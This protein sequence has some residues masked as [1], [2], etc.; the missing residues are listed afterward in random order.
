MAKSQDDALRKA[1]KEKHLVY[2]HGFLSSSE[3]FKA[4]VCE[5]YLASETAGITFHCPSLSSRPEADWNQ[6]ESLLLAI[7]QQGAVEL[8]VIGSSL[9]G[10]WAGA[11]CKQFAGLRAVLINPAVQPQNL[12]ADRIGVAL[13]YWHGEGELCLT[14]ADQSFIEGIEQRARPSAKELRR[15][16]VL[17]QKG[18]ETLD[19]RQAVSYYSG[20]VIELE[21]GGSHAFE[22]F[23][24]ALP[25]ILSFLFPTP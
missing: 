3:S 23:E 11:L 15:M 14:Q 9:G 6:L 1:P 25:R 13:S 24:Q 12:L 7:E 18:D 22:G 19:Y 2:V 20:A 5:G 10:F 17:L 8:G 16:K 4:Q 21:A